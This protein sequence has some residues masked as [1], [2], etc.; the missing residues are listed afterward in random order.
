MPDDT[1]ENTT[2]TNSPTKSFHGSVP[3]ELWGAY[4]L[5]GQTSRNAVELEDEETTL[6]RDGHVWL[7]WQH[8]DVVGL[9]QPRAFQTA[10]QLQRV[11]D[12][13]RLDDGGRQ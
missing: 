11:I 5:L 4:V 7:V 12:S 8:G 3:D 6:T 1:P 9:I 10:A 13:Y 2:S